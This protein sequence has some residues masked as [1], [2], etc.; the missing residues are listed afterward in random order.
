MIRLVNDM[1]E[2][3]V[4]NI[5]H[6]YQRSFGCYFEI[7]NHCIDE[8]TIVL[9]EVGMIS[10]QACANFGSGSSEHPK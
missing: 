8:M 1:Y 10:M 6:N 5:K 2:T 3:T 4:K 9:C 7:F